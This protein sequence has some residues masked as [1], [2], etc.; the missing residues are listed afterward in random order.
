MNDVSPLLSDWN[1]EH[2]QVRERAARLRSAMLAAGHPP[3]EA[4]AQALRQARAE[5]GVPR[6][7]DLV[8]RQTD[9]GWEVAERTV[10]NTIERHEGRHGAVTSAVHL[11]RQRGAKVIVVDRGG[12]E[13]GRQC[14]PNRVQ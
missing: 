5:L 4:M 13:L 1:N 11:A 2:P 7:G 12:Q 6:E 9:T 10:G 3:E 8:V 14:F